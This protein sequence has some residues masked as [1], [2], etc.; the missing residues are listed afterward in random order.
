VKAFL[1]IKEGNEKKL[2]VEVDGVEVVPRGFY[3]VDNTV[4]QY[5][6]Q[7][8]FIIEKFKAHPGVRVVGNQSHVMV[9]VEIMVEKYDGQL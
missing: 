2:L 1:F 8:T 4:Y 5:T 3:V 7:P 6:G 9:R